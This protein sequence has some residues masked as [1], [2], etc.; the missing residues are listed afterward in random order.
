MTNM[1]K[2]AVIDDVVSSGIDSA[3]QENLLDFFVHAMKAISATLAREAKFDTSD[4]ATANQRGC[5]AFQLR[6]CRLSTDDRAVWR[7]EITKGDQHLTVIG[8]LE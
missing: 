5:E 4:F 7:G 3:L 1:S 8:H 6:L 2:M